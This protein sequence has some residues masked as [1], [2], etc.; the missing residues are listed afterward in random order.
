MATWKLVLAENFDEFEWET[1]AKGWY[2]AELR[3]RGKVFALTFYDPVRL[4]QEI[5]DELKRCDAFFEEN[6]IVVRTVNRAH[7]ERAVARLLRSKMLDR[8]SPGLIKD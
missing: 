3:Y 1:E 7:M 2:P 4:Q 5:E 6:L 8:L